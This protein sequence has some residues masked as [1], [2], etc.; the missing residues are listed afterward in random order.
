MCTGPRQTLYTCSWS[1]AWE[2][3]AFVKHL[4]IYIYIYMYIYAR[5]QPIR[6]TLDM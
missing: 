2:V 4:D 6:P 5:L 3:A 1:A